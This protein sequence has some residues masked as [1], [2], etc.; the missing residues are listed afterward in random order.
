MHSITTFVSVLCLATSALA[1][2]GDYGS[3]SSSSSSNSAP[4]TSGSENGFAPA[5]AAPEAAVTSSSPST[6]SPSSDG[7]VTTHVIKVSNKN[8]DLKFEP[9]NLQAEAGHVVQFQFWPKN[10]SV[11]QST[12]DQP[13]V[14][15]NNVNSSI[16]GFFSGFMPIQADAT[17]RPTYTIVVN[18]TKPIWYYCSQGEHC[19]AGMVGVINPPA[20]NKSRTIE[21][22]T[23]LAA[24]APDN[25]SPSLEQTSGGTDGTT[26]AGTSGT[27]ASGTNTAAVANFTGAANSL[28]KGQ[29]TLA[30]L[31]MAG[32]LGFYITC[33]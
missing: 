13:C 25:V 17:T 30:S 15:I 33:L 4:D 14:P 11:V 1:Q 29:W 8:G 24:E 23:A 6:N 31:G 5:E 28:V 3:D 16:A 12:F 27:P 18:D 10:H 9:N 7:T 2:Y 20:Q 19:Q 21:S 26:P 22:F 32:V